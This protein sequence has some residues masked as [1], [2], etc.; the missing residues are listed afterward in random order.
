MTEYELADLISSTNENGFT[1]ITVM[2]SL[3]SGYLIVA[4]LVGNKLQTSQVGLINALFLSF[5]TL[6]GLAWAN[7]VRV[8][9]A[10]QVEL[11]E[12]NPDRLRVMGDW[13]LP[14]ASVFFIVVTLGCLKFMW[15]IRH[16]KTD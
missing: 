15:D 2:V 9:L 4:W 7:R 13:L 6:F 3:A 8:A 5:V 1:I 10:Y 14:A 11:L 12:I 16:P